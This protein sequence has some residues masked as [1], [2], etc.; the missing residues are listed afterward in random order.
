MADTTG[1][2]E[3]GKLYQLDLA[4]LQTDPNQPRKFLD[5]Q[6]LEELAACIKEHGHGL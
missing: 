1:A 3:K 4:H 5:P 6:A 2:Y